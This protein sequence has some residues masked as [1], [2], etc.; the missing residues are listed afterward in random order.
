MMETASNP[1]R[2]DPLG[3]PFKGWLYYELLITAHGDGLRRQIALCL[4]LSL[5]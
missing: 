2:R 5:S 4:S 3:E 1:G